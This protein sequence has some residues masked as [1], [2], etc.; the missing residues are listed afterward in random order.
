MSVYLKV[1]LDLRLT[2]SPFL[3][4]S[5]PAFA[6]VPVVETRGREHTEMGSCMHTGVGEVW[7]IDLRV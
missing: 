3:S 4:V 2:G 5:V 7:L 6:S 1:P